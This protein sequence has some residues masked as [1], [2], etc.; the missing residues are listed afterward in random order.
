MDDLTYRKLTKKEKS[1]IDKINERAKKRKIKRQYDVKF[2]VEAISDHSNLKSWDYD[3]LQDVE[4]MIDA[5]CEV[6]LKFKV[7][8]KKDAKEYKDY[9]FKE[10]GGNW[11]NDEWEERFGKIEEDA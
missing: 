2:I 5:I 3:C 4:D 11:F 9:Y 6:A 1:E 10:Y 8:T 7:W